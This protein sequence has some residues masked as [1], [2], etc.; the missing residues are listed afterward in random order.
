MLSLL[1]RVLTATWG[2]HLPLTSTC[3]KVENSLN[4]SP[5]KK[6]CLSLEKCSFG[7]LLLYSWLWTRAS[8]HGEVQIHMSSQCICS[9]ILKLLSLLIFHLAC[10]FPSKRTRLLNAEGLQS[11]HWRTVI[12]QVSQSGRGQSKLCTS[13]NKA[14][15]HTFAFLSRFSEQRSLSCQNHTALLASSHFSF[16]DILWGL[17]SPI[18]SGKGPCRT[19]TPKE[20]ECRSCLGASPCHVLGFLFRKALTHTQ[21]T[22]TGKR[23]SDILTFQCIAMRF[24]VYHLKERQVHRKQR[25]SFVRLVHCFPDSTL[26]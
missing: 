4:Q 9:L 19:S 18:P 26:L 24:S 1:T 2:K 13:E 17:S 10:S 3:Y 14:R 11:Q 5:G 15:V 6:D 20:G 12:W 21:H 25:C 8:A 16:G 7:E 22:A 23:R